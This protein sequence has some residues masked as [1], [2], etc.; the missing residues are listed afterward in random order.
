MSI[1]PK[2]TPSSP[3]YSV[4]VWGYVVAMTGRQAEYGNRTKRQ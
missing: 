1:N 4:S 3:R 2:T